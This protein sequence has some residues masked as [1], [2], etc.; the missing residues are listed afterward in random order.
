[1]TNNPKKLTGIDWEL[2]ERDYRA[3]IKSVRQIGKEYDVSR[4]AITK[5]A[6]K[7]GWPRDLKEKIRAATDAKLAK[8][9]ASQGATQVAKATENE[10][11]QANAD[12]QV[13][14]VRE[15]RVDIQRARK[16]AQALL[17]ALE[18]VVADRD[19][20][21]GLA[22]LIT[23]DDKSPK[24]YDTFMRAIG[25]PENAA[26]L[27]SLV[28][29]LKHLVGMEREAFGIEDRSGDEWPHP[30]PTITREMSIE[31]ASRLY[32]ELIKRV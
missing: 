5:R 19:L 1:M 10:I 18:R 30:L 6:Y 28:R 3:G 15:H 11:V 17:G 32:F 29:S 25:I 9:G 22:E 31:E 4:T 24:R 16:L 13:Q 21:E 23:Q 27:E 2:I 7:N 8:E 26:T 12:I 20:L 14:I